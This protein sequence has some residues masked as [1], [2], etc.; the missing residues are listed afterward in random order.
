[1]SKPTAEE[2]KKLKI[3][4]WVIAIN[5]ILWATLAILSI[6][7]PKSSR[8][9]QPITQVQQQP[10]E[11]IDY[12]RLLQDNTRTLNAGEYI[13]EDIFKDP[14]FYRVKAINPKQSGNLFI[15]DADGNLVTNE[16]IGDDQSYGIRE[17]ITVM[18]EGFTIKISG[19]DRVMFTPVI[20][21]GVTPNYENK[22]LVPG[23]YLVGHTV[24]AGKYTVTPSRSSGNFFVY[25]N[26]SVQANEILGGDYGIDSYNIELKDNDLIYTS[27][28]YIKLTTNN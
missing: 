12:K 14:S 15:Y 23:Y 6:T 25:R 5:I 9:Q 20:T 10:A 3:L 18:D 28:V 21:G 4:L 27:G 19:I 1:M 2:K 7:S 24:A 16:I 8:S 17:C 13:F 26:G 11:Q 22:T